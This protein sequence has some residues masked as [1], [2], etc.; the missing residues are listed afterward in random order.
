MG[1]IP[2]VQQS[3]SV[4]KCV[5]LWVREVNCI[6]AAFLSQESHYCLTWG[7]FS[8]CQSSISC[9]NTFKLSHSETLLLIVAI[10]I[11]SLHVRIVKSFLQPPS[12]NLF[13]FLCTR[14]PLPVCNLRLMHGNYPVWSETF[15]NCLFTCDLHCFFCQPVFMHVCINA[16]SWLKLQ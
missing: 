10:F 4:R 12:F 6:K 9:K 5:W 13:G 1:F 8:V 11:W 14:H 16:G 3:T 7:Q 15:Y 2:V